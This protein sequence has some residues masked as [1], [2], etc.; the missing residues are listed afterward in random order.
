MLRAIAEGHLAELEGQ[1]L[2][3]CEEDIL[4]RNIQDET[5][6]DAVLGLY[7]ETCSEFLYWT[8]SR[9]CFRSNPFAQR[10]VMFNY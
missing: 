10:R 6:D 1:I 5:F 9:E 7:I 8:K 3:V 4:N 2:P